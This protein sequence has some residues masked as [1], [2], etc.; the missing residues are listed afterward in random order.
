MWS[1]DDARHSAR[2][3]LEPFRQVCCLK[4]DEVRDRVRCRACSC[5]VSPNGSH[6]RCGSD[7]FTCRFHQSYKSTGLWGAAWP[8]PLTPVGGGRLL[9]RN[10]NWPLWQRATTFRAYLL[11]GNARREGHGA[12]ESTAQVYRDGYQPSAHVGRCAPPKYL[13]QPPCL[14]QCGA[15]Q[16]RLVGRITSIRGGC[17]ASAPRWRVR[18]PAY[19]YPRGWIEGMGSGALGFWPSRGRP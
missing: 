1:R 13:P 16:R 10:N 15:V 14:Q 17:V 2:E 4:S 19:C 7:T 8:K 12:A 18:R 6:V 5:S 9:G 11:A 3:T